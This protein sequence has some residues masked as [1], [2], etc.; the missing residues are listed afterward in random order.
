MHLNWPSEEFGLS[1][2]EAFSDSSGPDHTMSAR[3][4]TKTEG[5]ACV[6]DCGHAYTSLVCFR[7]RAYVRVFP[8]C[9]HGRR[10]GLFKV[11]TLFMLLSVA[12]LP[13]LLST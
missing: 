9:A 10:S 8:I 6:Y 4:S 3:A 11:L 12:R 1:Q 2:C 5:R 13:P 7:I